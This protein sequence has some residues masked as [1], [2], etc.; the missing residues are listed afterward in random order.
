M[1]QHRYEYEGPVEE[2]GRCICHRWCGATFAV[3]ESKARCNLTYQ[4]KKEFN[5]AP[6]TKVTL[7]GDIKLIY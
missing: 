4:F 5:K 7:P 3:S 1:E 2:F 6:G